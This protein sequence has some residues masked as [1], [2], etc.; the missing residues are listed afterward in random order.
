MDVKQC[1]IIDLK[2]TGD[3]QMFITERV[4]SIHKNAK[5]MWAVQF[6]TSPRTFNYNPA[7]LLYLKQPEMVNVEEKG[8]YINNRHITDVKELRCFTDGHHTYYHVTYNSGYY[9]N[10]EGKKVYITR[11]P[12]DKNGSSTWEYLNKLAAETGLVTKTNDNILSKQYKLVDVKRDNVPLAQ[13]LGDGTPL[14]T[15]RIPYRIY[16]PFGCNASQK[17]AVERALTHQVSIIQGP[18]GT[19]KTQT[20]LNIIAN[21][22]MAGKTVLVVSNN[23][24][25]VENV[26][27]KLNAEGL[28]FLVARLGNAENKETFIDQQRGY[29]AMKE[30]TLM[31]LYEVKQTGDTVLKKVT[32]GFDAQQRQAELKA[33]LGALQKEAKYD[34]LQ[35]NGA[36]SNKWLDRKPSA[37]LMRLLHLYQRQQE[38]NH[39]LKFFFRLKWAFTF[40]IKMFSFLRQEPSVVMKQLESAYYRARTAEMEQEITDVAV[41]LQEMDLKKNLADLRA[42]SLQSL[43]HAI[44]RRYDGRERRQFKIGDLKFQTAAFL[45]EY[46]IV[47]STT[48]SAKSCISKDMVFDYVIMDEASQVDIKTGALTLS[49]ATN[50]VIV[51]DDKQLPNVI[52]R[53]EAM[54]LNAIQSA[55]DVEEKYNTLTHSFLQTCIEVFSEAPSTLLREHYRCHPKIIDFCNQRFYDNELLTMTNDDNEEKVLQVVRT[56]PG[57]HARGHFNQREIDVISQE[58]MPEYKEMGTIGIITPYRHQA[59]EINKALGQDIASTVHKYQGKECDTIILSMV[60]NQPTPFSDDPN[61]LNVAISRAKK[62]LCVV[63]NGNEMDSE[64]ILAQLISY[65]RYNN[66]EVKESRMHSVFDLLYQRYTAER[67]AYEAEHP[68]LSDYLSENLIYD[69]LTKAIEKQWW[70]H[71]SLLSHYP[72]ARLV[73]NWEVLN[74]QEKAFAE[75]ALSHVDFLL[76]N[77]LTKQPRMAIEVDG[78]HFHQE[79]E[80][81]QSRD[82]LK[83]RI[84]EKIG[85]PLRRIST[86]ETVTEE[87]ITKL[88]AS[89]SN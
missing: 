62:H 12:I 23:N 82:A 66:F 76:Y 28:G 44:A 47:L 50:A 16:Y 6:G 41:A 58:V 61:L 15:Y 72:L 57:N 33:E 8:L 10:L 43:K 3:K 59:N 85:L 48:Y 17:M 20:I 80:A 7:R 4:S 63:T 51:G 18:P 11:T 87:Y 31:N 38:D 54:A 65:I 42:T 68:Q 26:A 45:Q 73:G 75:N 1:M 27:E 36:E 19:G 81:Q 9:E 84:L 83:D 74:D 14:N 5:G 69:L 34:A 79:S 22:L 29:P 39:K 40:G 56:V 60:D 30:W 86:T 70:T 64:S 67:L 78:W 25:A 49:C 2:K 13:F 55:Y 89:K 35:H 71:T 88:L 21:L 24:S 32:Q 53:E 46:P 37:Q 77:T 52:S